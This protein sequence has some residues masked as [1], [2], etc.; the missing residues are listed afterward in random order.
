MKTVLLQ[1]QHFYTCSPITNNYFL[2]SVIT[3]KLSIFSNQFVLKIKCLQILCCEIKFKSLL[4]HTIL[5]EK[6]Q[7]TILI[8]NKLS[9]IHLLPN[10]GIHSF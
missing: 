10:N 7:S 8:E 1:K 2:I 3:T 4:L 6:F 9:L 5:F